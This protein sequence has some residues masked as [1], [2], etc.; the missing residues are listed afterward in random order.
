[1]ELKQNGTYV[2]GACGPS[3]GGKTTVCLKIQDKIT[4]ILGESSNMICVVS[5][6]SYYNGGNESTNYDVP[7]SIDFDLLVEHL[8]KLINGEEV[9][10]PIYD[11]STHGRKEETKKTGPAKIIIIEGILIF[12]NERIR[13]LCN[14]KVFVEADDVLCY[15][16]RLKR[17]TQDRGRSF[18]DVENR[19]IDHVVPSFRNYV[20]PSRYHADVSL[21]NNT[22]GKFIGLEILLDHIEKKI[23]QFK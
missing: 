3:C 7:S 9:D 15:T 8:E 1:M 12:C 5:Q 23:N 13:N 19:Y 6:D 2:I 14:L 17:D 4:E 16:R 18:E 10:V 22:H 21:L 20:H 11:F